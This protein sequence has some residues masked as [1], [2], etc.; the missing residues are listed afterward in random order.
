[1]KSYTH[2][3]LENEYYSS[4]LY[5]PESLHNC[6]NTSLDSTT[7]GPVIIEKLDN[8]TNIVWNC[9]S[10]DSSLT[11]NNSKAKTVN[12]ETG[13]NN[14]ISSETKQHENRPQLDRSI[15]GLE[16]PC[17]IVSD[18]HTAKNDGALVEI[19]TK[20][21]DDEEL[22]SIENFEPKVI[23]DVVKEE[24]VKIGAIRVH[25]DVKPEET[26]INACDDE[27]ERVDDEDITET[28]CK[29]LA[30]DENTID[31]ANTV[32]ITKS[33][34][35]NEVTNV[36]GDIVQS[37]DGTQSDVGEVFEEKEILDNNIVKSSGPDIEKQDETT[38]EENNTVELTV[39][40]DLPNA[41]KML[42]SED[43]VNDNI[44]YSKKMDS[45]VNMDNNNIYSNNA[46]DLKSD[47]N[48]ARVFLP[49]RRSSSTQQ[50][51]RND[52]SE[53]REG[54]LDSG[55]E[56]KAFRS[57]LSSVDQLIE[58]LASQTEREKSPEKT[59]S[60]SSDTPSDLEKSTAE[61]KCQKDSCENLTTEITSF[62]TPENPLEKVVKTEN[63]GET[64]LGSPEEFV[65]SENNEFIDSLYEPSCL[66][67]G[68]DK[69]DEHEVCPELQDSNSNEIEPNDKT[70]EEAKS[71]SSQV[72]ENET[73]EK[74][75]QS[76]NQL[77]DSI[78]I[79]TNSLKEKGKSKTLENQC[80]EGEEISSTT[81]SPGGD[82]ESEIEVNNHAE[83]RE[84]RENEFIDSLY[85]PANLKDSLYE[86]TSLKD[87]LYEQGNLK[88]EQQIE[89]Q[90]EQKYGS[91]VKYIPQMVSQPV[92]FD[93]NY[94][95]VTESKS[96]NEADQSETMVAPSC[97][98]FFLSDVEQSETV[99]TQSPEGTQGPSGSERGEITYT[100][101]EY[102]NRA[103]HAFRNSSHVAGSDKTNQDLDSNVSDPPNSEN[104]F[105]LT[106]SGGSPERSPS[107]D[108][109]RVNLI[110]T[111][112]A[113]NNVKRGTTRVDGERFEGRENSS[114]L[115]NLSSDSL[116]DITLIEPLDKSSDIIET[117]SVRSDISQDSLCDD[118]V[119]N[120]NDNDDSVEGNNL[121][122]F[123]DKVSR[124]TV[125]TNSKDMISNDHLTK[126][127]K[128]QC[129]AVQKGQSDMNE[130]LSSYTDD[131]IE[132]EEV[133]EGAASSQLSS[134]LFETD[135]TP[136]F[137]EQPSFQWPVD[138]TKTTN[139]TFTRSDSKSQ[140]SMSS[141]HG[142]VDSS[143]E[144]Y[145]AIPGTKLQVENSGG[146]TFDF[147]RM[148]ESLRQESFYLNNSSGS[149]PRHGDPK[150][151]PEALVHRRPQVVEQECD[152][153]SLS[154]DSLGDDDDYG[155]LSEGEIQILTEYGDKSLKVP[156][157]GG[158]HLESI[159]EEGQDQLLQGR[160]GR[161]GQKRS[162][163]RHQQRSGSQICDGAAL[164]LGYEEDAT[165]L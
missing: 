99:Y 124:V 101:A 157:R 27:N 70:P 68:E 50:L 102:P 87:S 67:D 123:P 95:E 29:I 3:A 36:I 119:N 4:S 159:E 88:D 117:S 74:L 106:A 39:C 114:N 112:E 142:K 78:K 66:K 73:E 121:K 150:L 81:K 134:T 113:A 35:A 140:N 14:K 136:T 164:S 147:D 23:H 115:H 158:D 72:V 24:I 79:F 51:S 108:D 97:G 49:R 154:S 31:K 89:V 75:L 62:G 44:A 26:E 60:E 127:S 109:S 144:Q 107:L 133:V 110:G 6:H 84:Q 82:Q 145:G 7:C 57:P 155:D 15:N 40:I 125:K 100:W 91:P 37:D 9:V 5:K 148:K 103:P 77:H 130:T 8:G 38:D 96:E 32:K 104:T 28:E 90:K 160:R 42:S 162:M 161:K 11:S 10:P 128:S 111:L 146:D 105:E 139:N 135:T 85:E 151:V 116:E 69:S 13:K 43:F 52:L 137:P 141:A 65:K 98:G 30:D 61:N 122:C 120:N 33:D 94:E 138:S 22:N 63:N 19:K 92:F 34:D 126:V 129:C 48:E 118:D 47:R 163:S 54:D 93:S 64:S 18:P 46:R 59:E 16:N 58:I 153:D 83:V 165:A 56:K 20:H 156:P 41:D 80:D 45:V 17:A 149:G 71:E 25:S 53:E 2:D 131:S 143:V 132:M 86:T 12:K 21:N 55:L 152:S 1:M 76:L